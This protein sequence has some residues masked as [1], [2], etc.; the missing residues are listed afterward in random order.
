MSLTGDQAG[1]LFL[2]PAL[3]YFI[4]LICSGFVSGKLLHKKPS[5]C[6]QS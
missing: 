6:L 1:S 2:M 3:G 4:T 5:A